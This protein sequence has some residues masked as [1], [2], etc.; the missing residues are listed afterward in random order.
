MKHCNKLWMIVSLLITGSAM[1][2]N[3]PPN[4]GFEAGTFDNWQCS[5]GS[6]NRDGTLNL[7]PSGPV[8]DRHTLI[9]NTLPQGTDPY[10]GFP[11]SCPNG[12]GYSVRLGNSQ[13]GGQAEG[14]SYTFTIPANQNDYSIIYNYAVVFEN[15]THLPQEQPRFIS[16]VFNVTDNQYISCGSF[17]FVASSNLP[18]FQQA[19]GDVFYKP[20]SPVTVNL[21]GYAG[22]TVR[23][24]FTTNDCAFVRH[25]GYAYLDVNEDCTS[26]AITGSTYCGGTQSLV[27]RGPYGF[28]SYRWFTSD[29]SQVLGTGSILTVTPPPP[30]NTTYALEIIPYDGLGCQDTIFT[31]IH[32][33][34]QPYQLNVINQIAGCQPGV[35][36]TIPAV[37]AGSTPGMIYSYYLDPDELNYL[38]TPKSITVSGTYY[39]RGVNS[40]GCSDIKP[41][42][43]TVLPSPNLV[44]SNPEGVCVPKTIDITLPLTTAGSDAGLS[45]SYWKNAGATIPLPNPNAITAAGI[46]YIKG[47]GNINTCTT[48][49]PVDVKIGPI[50]NVVITDPASCGQVDLTAFSVTS[51]STPGLN[52]TYW[53]DGAATLSLPQPNAVTIS[54]NYFIKAN[55][56]LGCAIIKPVIATVKPNPVFTVTDPAPVTYPVTTVNITKSIVPV[57]GIT[58]TYWQDKQATKKLGS[59]AVIDKSGTYYIKAVNQFQCSVI[60]P[61]N[62]KIIP[63]PDPIIFAPNA[64]SPNKD[65]VNDVF[66]IKILGEITVRSLKVYNRWGQVV[67]NSADIEAGWNGKAQGIEQPTAAYIW[68]LDGYDEYYKKRIGAKGIVT[69]IR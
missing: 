5:S 66:R 63:S 69:L 65:G 6:V 47:V 64:F 35:D 50:P 9:A 1:S 39:I 58:F 4:I 68:M 27:L 18:G 60:N 42:N 52:Y 40:A 31:T 53:T 48:T 19:G 46:Y 10:G 25:F 32:L 16:K 62:V 43:V 11:T 33:S 26:G 12:S 38:A 44:I 36:I 22:K 51:G 61:V 23:L 3:C 41:I 21:S 54:G 56:D 15:P 29:F 30:S 67:Y 59:P 55:S 45:Y 13:A 28:Q 20:W 7:S 17:Q 57:N 37:T 14:I 34:P 2:Q 8:A 49:K 24:E